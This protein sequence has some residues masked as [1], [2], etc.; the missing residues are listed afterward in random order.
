MSP[1]AGLCRERTD[2]PQGRKGSPWRVKFVPPDGGG[3]RWVVGQHLFL[4]EGKK[5]LQQPL[6]KWLLEGLQVIGIFLRRIVE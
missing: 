4:P 6:R 3:L 5:T 2:S 1:P